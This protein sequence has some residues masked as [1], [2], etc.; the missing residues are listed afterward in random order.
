[1]YF[2]IY[3]V[4][5]I[6]FSSC[7]LFDFAKLDNDLVKNIDLVCLDADGAGRIGLSQKK[8]PFT[9]ES[10]LILDENKWLMNL[11]FTLWGEELIQLDLNN[12]HK[13]VFMTKL[14]SKM[15]QEQ[16]INP[17]D[18]S[19]FMDAWSALIF[20]LVQIKNSKKMSKNSNFIWTKNSKSLIASKRIKESMVHVE[21]TRMYQ[22][23]FSEVNIALSSLQ[24]NEEK[25]QIQLVVRKCLAE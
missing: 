20:E 6:L 9:Y 12:Q 14:D 7:S 15:L 13:P 1:M 2:R 17:T 5:F 16:N 21:F 19:D 11:N 8:Y 22:N 4:L 23:Y 3:F 24:N 10:V 25:V 18:V